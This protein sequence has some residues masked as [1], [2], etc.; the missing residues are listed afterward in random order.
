VRRGLGRAAVLIGAITVLARLAGFGRTLVFAH[1]VGNSSLGTAYATA[2]QV[3]NIIFDIVAG[4]ALTAVVVPVLAGPAQRAGTDRDAAADVG[5]TAS[6]LLTWTLMLLVPLSVILALV[7]EPVVTVLLGRGHGGGSAEIVSVATRMLVVFAPQLALYGLAVVLYGIL[8]SHHRFAAPALAPLLSSLV[9]SAAYLAFLPLGN[10][11]QNDLHGLSRAAELTLSVGT[12]AGVA[13]LVVAVA[14]PAWRLRLRLRPSLRFPHGVAPRVRGLAAAGIAALVAQDAS[15]VAVIVLA[16]SRGGNGA[17]VLYNYGWQMFFLPYAVLAVPVA[18]SAFPLLSAHAAATGATL[19]AGAGVGVPAEPGVGVPAEAGVGVPAEPG[20]GVP[21]EPGVGVPA[22]PGVGV[23]AKPGVGV[24]A[25]AG[26]GVPAEPGRAM[27]AEAGPRAPGEA[28]EAGPR[29]PGGAG[30]A[31]RVRQA[32]SAAGGFDA[33]AATSTRAAVLVCFLGAAVLAGTAA[34]AARVFVGPASA[35]ELAFTF[36]AFAPGLIGYG[37]VANLSRVLLAWGRSRATALTTVAGWLVVMVADLAVVPFVPRR[38]VVPA[39]GLGNTIGLTVAGAAL[40]IAVVHARSRASVR[41]LPRA[42]AAGLAGAVAGGA[43]AAAAA[44]AATSAFRISGALRAAALTIVAGAAAVAVFLVVA[45]LAD[46]GDLR[47]VTARV[48]RRRPGTSPRAAPDPAPDP[49]A[50]R[51]PDRAPDRAADPAADRAPDRAPDPAADRAPDPAADRAPDRAPGPAPDPAPVKAVAFVLGVAAG[52]TG[53][54]V[55]SLA[56]GLAARGAEV[57]VF[58]PGAT[59]RPGTWFSASPGGHGAIQGTPP[60]PRRPGT[61]RGTGAGVQFTPVE[62]ADR[63]RP[64][65]DL[66]A[67]ARLRRLLRQFVPEI[68]HA[69]GLR[70]GALTALALSPAWRRARPA[71]LVTVHNAPPAAGAVNRAIYRLLERIVARRADRVLCVSCDLAERMRRRGARATGRAVVPAPAAPAVSAETSHAVRAELAATGRPLV[72]G[73]GRLAAQKGFGTLL[74]AAALW[75]SRDPR[76]LVVVAGDGPLGAELSAR[77]DAERLPLR[78]L[79]QRDDV[80]ALLA[81]ADVFVLPS[82]WEGQPLI[83]QE[84]LRAGVPIVA[85]RTGGIPCMTGEE[86]AVLVP[87]GDPERFAAAVA[88]VLDEPGLAARLAHAAAERAGSLPDEAGAVDAALAEYRAALGR[89]GGPPL[90]PTPP[91]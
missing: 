85:T 45:Y 8:Q 90:R 47:A 17:I 58:G 86:A 21:A 37:L 81:A 87:V 82:I 70:A 22:E 44:A 11:H 51:A 71:F 78:L 15:L 84:A 35:R 76:P 61:P 68:V 77:I 7:A 40:L 83:L 16:N 63:P 56:A 27:P 4:G 41:G 46:S 59:Q 65:R 20:V 62:I 50:D 43:A 33:V 5:R 57:R 12:T 88:R 30:G 67:V 73:A 14:V 55:G 29:A 32:V 28:G 80:P 13:A 36:V 42:F 31:G 24:P 75:R 10:G 54:H 23:P 18:T 26:V 2:N 79:G 19:A 3:P 64:A 48:L 38:W 9:V 49:A 53:A 52:G 34:P 72:V 91:A 89:P 66:A 1:T 74:D 39:L 6:A 60:D 25:E 69:H